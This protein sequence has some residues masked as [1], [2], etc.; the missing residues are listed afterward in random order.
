MTFR[1][2]VVIS[3]CITLV[4]AAPSL[5]LGSTANTVTAR[6]DLKWKDMGNGVKAAPVWGDMQKG[7][8]RFFLKYPAGLET[9]RHYHTA[10]HYGT[11]VSGEVTLVV[12]GKSS[13]LGPGAYISLAGKAW[14][15]AKV[16][17]TDDVV[18]FIHADGPWDAVFEK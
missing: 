17:G 11:V 4:T 18:F 3:V 10:D 13:R 14:H 5:V 15:T 8:S 16:E 2:A 9:P 1:N 7:P 6:A 12:E